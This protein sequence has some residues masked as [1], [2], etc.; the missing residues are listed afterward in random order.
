MKSYSY[1]ILLVFAFFLTGCIKDELN[2]NNQEGE[3]KVPFIKTPTVYDKFVGDY[4]VY[5]TLFNYSHN[6]SIAHFSGINQY[7]IEVDSLRLINFADSFNF[8]I[9]FRHITNDKILSLGIIDTLF[10]HSGKRFFFWSNSDDLNTSNIIENELVNDTILLYYGL[11]NIK[12][13][14]YENVPYY[15][16]E[17][18]QY[19]VKQH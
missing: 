3:I 15:Q 5:D 16:C 6:M 18:K 11:D 8:E 9:K 12:Y 2:L 7:G 19:A 14:F 10:T 13:Y 4:K 1:I 17:C